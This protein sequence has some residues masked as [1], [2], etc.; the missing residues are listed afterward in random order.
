[1]QS[2]SVHRIIS[3]LAGLLAVAVVVL[4]ISA[5][6][7]FAYRYAAGSVQT[8]AES[9]SHRVNDVVG[10]NPEMWRFEHVRLVDI[11][12]Q[13]SADAPDE[14]RRVVDSG[15]ATV[16]GYGGAVQ[17]PR[18]VRSRP[19]L[20]AGVQVGRIEIARSLRPIALRASIVAALL[21]P[22]AFLAFS[23][24]RSI[25][26][27]AIRKGE[28][29]L[30]A[31]E[32]RFRALT[33]HAT[34]MVM[35]FDARYRIQYWSRGATELLGWTSPEVT[36]KRLKDL[37]L[38][39]PEDAP[40]VAM[41][42]R[43]TVAGGRELIPFVARIRHRDGSWRFIEGAGR[44]L[45]H[46][47]AVSGLVVNARDV[48]EERRLE[49]QFRQSQKL[50]SLGRLAG[51]V[52]HDFNNLLTVILGGSQAIREALARGRPVDPEDPEHIQVAGERAR[53]LTGQLLAFARK[54]V[55]SP[56]PLDLNALVRGSERLLGRVL[57]ADIQFDVHPEAGL[58]PVLC[59]PGQMEQ[60]L[61]NLAVNARDAMPSGGKLV[62]ET[63]NALDLGEAGADPGASSG[64]W[65]H[66]VVR[67][68]GSGM[69]PEVQ[70]RIFEPFFT[71][72][73]LGKGTGLGL[74]MVHG[75]VT[76]N[77]GRVRVESKPGLGT[78]FEIRFPRTLAVAPVADARAPVP[79]PVPVSA[80]PPARGSETILVV[81]DDP[82]V[83]WVTVRVLRGAGHRVLVASNGAEAQDIAEQEPGTLH[84]V[85]TDVL[86]P[87]MSGREVVEALRRRFPG[88]PALFVSGYPR[89]IIAKRGVLDPGTE[90]LAKP[91]MPAAL[92]ERVRAILD[93]R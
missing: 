51:G 40:A 54:Q 30:R 74:A 93:A 9:N 3:I 81:E 5:Y 44:N 75:I 91:F 87:G 63:R 79:A 24:L 35:V 69:S 26:L 52:A 53:D 14:E 16:A 45:L 46:D 71:T 39:H 12:S 32:A 58:W 59:D 4:P 17:W 62:I 50:E 2:R 38:I 47:P 73:E 76:Q 60:L 34:D 25:P 1:M 18:I 66:L 78:A 29:D 88:L 68:T 86:M 92:L 19:I 89:E 90:F 22:L 82:G 61:L 8:E 23:L 84:L 37:G 49:E 41:A 57:G 27:R 33:E 13:R 65:V 77:G 7:L 43:T 85:V 31:S 67:D 20:D 10:A 72:K 21:V 83:R 11:L 56:V 28:E 42:T 55:I 80:P 48:T 64:Q 15:G 6:L 36:G 70:E